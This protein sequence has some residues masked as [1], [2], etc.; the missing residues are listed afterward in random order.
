MQDNNNQM[1]S[2]IVPV[3]NVEDYIASCIESILGQTYR[4]LE[5]ILVDDG[6]TDSSAQICELY[7]LQDKRLRLFTQK[8]QGASSARN[9][10]IAACKGSWIVFVDSDDL[11]RLDAIEQLVWAASNYNV[12]IVCSRLTYDFD[13][14]NEGLRAH[15]PSFRVFSPGREL[16]HY[17]L[18]GNHSCG[19]LYASRLFNSA[20]IRYPEGRRYEEDT[21]TTYLLFEETT[22]VAMTDSALYFYRLREDSVTAT[23]LVADTEDLR[24]TY[25]EVK[26]FYEN[27]SSDS[28]LMFQATILYQLLRMATIAETSKEQRKRVCGYVSGEYSNAMFRSVLRHL[29]MPMGK[30]LLLMKLGLA[31]LFIKIRHRNSKA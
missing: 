4:N 29:S 24:K 19:K 17:S 2:V 9:R 13:E 18:V 16:L 21:A 27:D 6:S 5:V 12:D 10:G 3:Y 1:V 14:F 22:E 7:A 31:P 30:K 26:I 23:P 25:E 20:G 11:L 8:N 15:E 28:C